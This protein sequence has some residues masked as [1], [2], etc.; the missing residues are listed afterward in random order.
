MEL[1]NYRGKGHRAS[2]DFFRSI[3]I[4]FQGYCRLIEGFFNL[5]YIFLHN[6]LFFKKS[7]S[8]SPFQVV[9]FVVHIRTGG[10]R[11]VP[12]LPY[13]RRSLFAFWLGQ[14][15]NMRWGWRGGEEKEVPS[16]PLPLPLILSPFALAPTFALNVLRVPY[17]LQH[18]HNACYAGYV[19]IAAW[20]IARIDNVWK[21]GVCMNFVEL[22]SP[23]PYPDKSSRP[24]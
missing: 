8:G 24:V 12:I 9:Y 13:V 21:S 17:V 5:F 7:I 18:A 1:W 14:A 10:Q 15:K 19:K 20:K 16:F 3:A 22:S 11:N 6:F 2:S 4:A 23:P